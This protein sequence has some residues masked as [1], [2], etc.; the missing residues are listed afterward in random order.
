MLPVRGDG[1]IVA[2]AQRVR[3]AVIGDYGRA[4]P[5]VATVANLVKG[6]DPDLVIT[7]GD[8]NYPNG[9]ADTIDANIGQ[10]YHPFIGPYTGRYG[11]G[12]MHNRFF[13]AL[14]N[15]DW[16]NGDVKPYADYFTLPGNE[17][18]YD[19]VAG[20]VHLFAVDSDGREP[21]GATADSVQAAWLK[22]RLA[23]S[24]AAWKV[25]YMHHP[26]YSSGPHRSSEQMRW[27]FKEWGA[28]IVFA[29][30][31]HVYERLEIAGLT[32][33]VNGLGGASLYT[34]TEPI[35]GSQVRFDSNYG[36]ALVTA[37]PATFT[38]RFFAVDGRM[39]DQLV[40]NK[41]PLTR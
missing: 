23:S 34:M 38:L 24:T 15:H 40:L 16:D 20:D 7:T 1:G 25:V 32:Y 6:W 12:S 11:C 39:I 29:G 17:R 33:I 13:P 8:N 18:Y 21:D 3:F 19:T 36:A 26:P 22:R 30:H 41:R 37:E 2:N 10:Y 5:N 14:G 27:P 31:D 35:P 28:D 9:S 4:G